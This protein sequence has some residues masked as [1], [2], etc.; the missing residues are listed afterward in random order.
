VILPVGHEGEFKIKKDQMHLK[1]PDGDRKTRAY[2]VVGAKPVGSD[3]RKEASEHDIRD[4]DVRDRDIRDKDQDRV[5]K[6][7]PDKPDPRTSPVARKRATQNNGMLTG[8]N[9]GRNYRVQ[10]L[11]NPL[12]AK[13]RNAA[14]RT[15][16]SRN[17][18]IEKG[19][20]SCGRALRD[21]REELCWSWPW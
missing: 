13:C 2:Q 17:V 4:H 1:I 10:T 11:K 20:D 21:D 12:D 14:A 15:E 9:A 6:K 18:L 5:A 3:R 19:G 7:S 8:L 16:L